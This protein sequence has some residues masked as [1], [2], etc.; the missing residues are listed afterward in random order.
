MITVST[1]LI[2]KIC[3]LMHLNRLPARSWG[4]FGVPA[5]GVE[6]SWNADQ[7]RSQNLCEFCTV[8]LSRKRL[9]IPIT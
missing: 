5:Y 8:L 6:P 7:S 4:T 9:G 2:A 1:P 3:R